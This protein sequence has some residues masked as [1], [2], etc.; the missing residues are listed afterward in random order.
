MSNL[1]NAFMSCPALMSD[2]RSQKTDYTS[3]NELLKKMKG[4][5]AT[6]FEFRDNL[7]A[8]GLRD[9]TP[10]VIY[11]VCG[12]VPAGDVV[13]DKKIDL[14]TYKTG[15]FLSAFAPLSSISFFSSITKPIIPNSQATFPA[16]ALPE[17]APLGYKPSKKDYDSRLNNARLVGNLQGKIAA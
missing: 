10:D 17:G 3:H 13:L 2:G 15:S 7:Q 14:T 4:N 11:N 6:S 9:L 1:D 16:S 8:S 5:T 12:T